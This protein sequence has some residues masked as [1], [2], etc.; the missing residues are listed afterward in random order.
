L[1]SFIFREVGQSVSGVGL[2]TDM[3]FMEE[4][5]LRFHNIAPERVKELE[6]IVPSVTDAIVQAWNQ[7]IKTPDWLKK[8]FES[9]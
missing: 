8:E 9:M 3:I 4:K 6:G 7:E 1:A 5:R 2:G